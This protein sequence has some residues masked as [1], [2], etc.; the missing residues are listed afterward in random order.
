MVD[1]IAVCT[2]AFYEWRKSPLTQRDWM[3]HICVALPVVIRVRQIVH[4]AP[5]AAR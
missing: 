3:T 2:Q 1:G 5:P 4:E